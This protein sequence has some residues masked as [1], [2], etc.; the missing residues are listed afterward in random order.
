MNGRDVALST[1]RLKPAFL[2]NAEEVPESLQE[3]ITENMAVAHITP[4][5]RCNK[6]KKVRFAPIHS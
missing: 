6:P 4:K 1:E 2:P 3:T 5:K